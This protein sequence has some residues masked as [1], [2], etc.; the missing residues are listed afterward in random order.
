VAGE[1]ALYRSHTPR[2]LIRG[3]LYLGDESHN[4]V[5]PPAAGMKKMGKPK[6][7][8]R[9]AAVLTAPVVVGGFAS[10][11]AQQLV[12]TGSSQVVRSVQQI[13]Q[14]ATS[15]QGTVVGV[16]GGEYY[17]AGEWASANMSSQQRSAAVDLATKVVHLATE[18]ACVTDTSPEYQRRLVQWILAGGLDPRQAAEIALDGTEAA[19]LAPLIDQIRSHPEHWA[20]A[21][22]A[23]S[24]AAD[25]PAET[26][27][28]RFAALDHRA[29]GS[30]SGGG[31]PG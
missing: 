22:S 11:A 5:L 20:P 23:S 13:I 26:P 15:W 8:R 21:G 27:D 14:A 9:V 28:Q 4:P 10:G 19:G 29:G 6:A 7:R 17:L 16:G 2:D 12:I 3:G 1:W 30:A 24:T 18:K 31:P 25:G